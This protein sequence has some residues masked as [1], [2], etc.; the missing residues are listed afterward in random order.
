MNYSTPFFKKTL[1]FASL[2]VLASLLCSNQ[3]FAM[4]PADQHPII[5]TH[6]TFT[7]NEVETLILK[8][9]DGDYQAQDALMQIYYRGL[10]QALLTPERIGF[11]SWKNQNLDNSTKDNCYHNDFYAYFV[12]CHF[13]KLGEHF[14]KLFEITKARAN[15]GDAGAQNNIGCMFTLGRGV[16]KDEKEAYNYF[17]LAVDQGHPLAQCVFGI[18]YEEG[19][20]IMLGLDKDEKEAF[21]YYK[22][23]AD[24]GLAKA[25]Y[26]LGDMYEKG[27]GV[28]KD[29]KEACNYYKLAAAQG[30]ADAQ[31]NLGFK[32]AYG[33]GVEKNEKEACNYY[34]LAVAQKHPDAQCQ[35]GFM[36]IYGRG[37]AKDENK[38]FIYYKLSADQGHKAAQCILGAMYIEGQCVDKDEKEAFKYYKLSADQRDANARFVLG[39]MYANGQ[40]V[41]KDEEAAIK[42]YKLSADQ[43]NKDA[44]WAL[45]AMY[46]EGH[47]VDKDEKEAFKYFKMAADE[48]NAKAQQVIGFMYAE[49][50]GVEKN[51]IE[52]LHWYIKSKDQM[53]EAFICKHLPLIPNVS[54]TGDTFQEMLVEF[55]A[56]NNPNI[57]LEGGVAHLLTSYQL[58]IGM[59]KKC[60]SAFAIPEL[61]KMYDSIE[62]LVAGIKNGVESLSTIKPG[63]MLT[64]VSLSEEM[65]VLLPNQITPFFSLDEIDGISYLTMGEEN[66]I[67][68]NS[69][70]TFLEKFEQAD[71]TLKKIAQLYS[72]GLELVLSELKAKQNLAD[73]QNVDDFLNLAFI[74]NSVE[75]FKKQEEECNKFRSSHEKNKEQCTKFDLD[76]GQLMVRQ[77]L[78]LISKDENYIHN[79][80]ASSVQ[81]KGY[82]DSLICIKNSVE[83][84]KEQEDKFNDLVLYLNL[85][86]QE[87]EEERALL[88][89]LH[90]QI[91]A[92]PARGVGSRNKDFLEE[93]PYLL[94]Q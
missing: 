19:L 81:V 62:I 86:L 11:R 75:A 90:K 25:Q 61:G 60:F 10:Y 52:A 77:R 73:V 91:K 9:K 74:N 88:C 22:H 71:Q 87:I 58:K 37:V 24:K 53:A 49:G 27:R 2:V 43:G 8:A 47:C 1:G 5:Q 34:E 16:D 14:P 76:L 70:I 17:K 84:F 32:Y 68:A 54:M 12:I 4:E 26:N 23:A 57:H 38:A 29:E 40:G 33:L 72:Q 64:A 31:Y 45:G 18:M 82:F 85:P 39:I 79:E 21:K 80:D 51:L 42:Y 65:K 56:E 30:H 20:G 46:I 28:E 41:P 93:H 55:V 13:E 66:V 36:Y 94:K 3:S 69:F 83:A 63:F 48:G 59:N 44:Q 7:L 92:L 50:L 89:E 6:Q 67:K 78:A 35:L 15:L